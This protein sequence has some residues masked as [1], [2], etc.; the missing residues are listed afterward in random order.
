MKETFNKISQEKRERIINSSIEE[1]AEWGY[2]KGSTDRIIVRSG[3]SKGGLYEYISSKEDLFLFVVEHTYSLLYDHIVKTIRKDETQWPDDILERF[4]FVAR[5]AIDFYLANPLYIKLIIK[6]S[7]IIDEDIR[8]RVQQLFMKHFRP[9]F[10]TASSSGLAF[11]PDRVLDL[12]EWLLMKTRNH[13]LETFVNAQDASRVRE[14]YLNEWDFIISVMKH[15][16]YLNN[17][18]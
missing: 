16:I 1:F 8:T 14:E 9:L 4:S 2:E 7:H 17:K 5:T 13:F 15:G 11:D 12:M 10:G 6:T 18:E 3:I